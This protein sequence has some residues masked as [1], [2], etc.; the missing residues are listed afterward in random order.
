MR[1]EDI[2]LI[3]VVINQRLGAGSLEAYIYDRHRQINKEIKA[4]KSN[5]DIP[6]QVT[7][8]SNFF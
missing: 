5:G 7:Y 2:H 1:F 8:K 3:S 6:E 4:L